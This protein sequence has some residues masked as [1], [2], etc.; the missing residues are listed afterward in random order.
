M[1][2]RN[3]ILIFMFFL[4]VSGAAVSGEDPSVLLL[5][6]DRSVEKYSIVQEEFKKNLKFPVEEIYINNYRHLSRAGNIFK[7]KSYDL[8]FCIGTKAYMTAY[9]NAGNK[10]IVFSSIINWQRLPQRP[11]IFGVANEPHVALEIMVFRHIFPAIRKIGVMYSKKF[12]R[13]WVENARDESKKFG[14][15]LIGAQVPDIPPK[16]AEWIALL[17]RV[18]ALW[19]ISDP[20]IIPRKKNLV[21][22]MKL[23]DH[24]KMPVFSYNNVFIKYGAVLVITADDATIG[25]QAAGIAQ[26]VL[27]GKRKTPNVQFPA[28][29]Q[30]ILNLKQAKAY[31]LAY[32]ED[33]FG[34]INRIIE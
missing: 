17:S 5:N 34:I 31:K 8:V 32:K 20:V 25:R 24:Y 13:Q 21:K 14:I 30:V 29:T 16:K 3:F 26:D 22:L 1:K 18:D 27:A 23:C 9:Q 12:N 4:L 6:S 7:H 33:A 19:L 10:D 2:G 15:E 11:G 28:G